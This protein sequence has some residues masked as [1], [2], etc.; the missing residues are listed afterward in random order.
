MDSHEGLDWR[1]KA[2]ITGAVV[3]AVAGIGAAYLYIR[4]IEETGEP[5]ALA[6]KDAVTIG[7]S[8]AALIRQVASLGGK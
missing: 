5:P 8:L 2:L 3:G 4:N 6:T 7:V 1:T